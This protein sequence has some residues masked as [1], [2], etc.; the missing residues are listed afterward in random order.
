M[1]TRN[2]NRNRLGKP[3]CVTAVVTTLLLVATATSTPVYNGALAKKLQNECTWAA[4]RIA[5]LEAE[6]SSIRH[7]A[8]DSGR[9]QTEGEKKRVR[10]INSEIG[11]LGAFITKYCRRGGSSTTTEFNSSQNV[12]PDVSVLPETNQEKDSS[13]NSLPGNSIP[14]S[15]PS[16]SISDSIVDQEQKD[17]DEEEDRTTDRLPI[18]PEC[19]AGYEFD[20]DTKDC[21]PY[22]ESKDDKVNGNEENDD[23]DSEDDDSKGEDSVSDAKMNTLKG[24]KTDK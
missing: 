19:K 5:E 17:D 13:K 12:L 24:E 23:L 16:I 8:R 1:E 11:Q 18:V 7:D 20:F 9:E 21:V 14:I 2:H 15:E 22:K 10:E 3:I 4:A 6:R